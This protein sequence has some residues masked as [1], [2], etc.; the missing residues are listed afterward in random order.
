MNA[1]P[2]APKVPITQ[3]HE[4][5]LSVIQETKT[6]LGDI[7]GCHDLSFCCMRALPASFALFLI[8]STQPIFRLDG[9]SPSRLVGIPDESVCTGSDMVKE[10]F[11]FYENT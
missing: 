1:A 3:L 11:R 4:D 9:S 8:P 6:Y 10:N 7:T 2:K 5:S